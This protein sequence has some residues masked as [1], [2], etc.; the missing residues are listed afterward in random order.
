MSAMADRRNPAHRNLL[1]GNAC[2]YDMRTYSTRQTFKEEQH[3]EYMNLMELRE[4]ARDILLRRSTTERRAC[5]EWLDCWVFGSVMLQ[6]QHPGKPKAYPRTKETLI[7][8][9]AWIAT[10]MVQIASWFADAT[11]WQMESLKG[12]P[13]GKQASTLTL[14]LRCVCLWSIPSKGAHTSVM[15]HH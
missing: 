9:D 8:Y 15:S 2:T 5:P 13:A 3:A 12:R 11:E 14:S 10:Y 4:V 6:R 7:E 1:R